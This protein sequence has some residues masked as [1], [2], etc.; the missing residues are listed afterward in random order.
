MLGRIV[1][2]YFYAVKHGHIPALRVS[3]H[4]DAENPN[5]LVYFAVQNSVF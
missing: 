2:T 3:R 5:F 1:G 4:V